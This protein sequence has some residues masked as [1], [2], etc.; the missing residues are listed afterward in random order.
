M[1]SPPTSRCSGPPTPIGS[2]VSNADGLL[3][4]GQFVRIEVPVED[5]ADLGT[6]VKLWG[7]GWE[8]SPRLTALASRRRVDTIHKSRV[9]GASKINLDLHAGHQQINGISSRVFEVLCCGGFVLT[10][11]RKDL[12]EA[13]D[14]GREIDVFASPEEAKD[15][16]DYYLAHPEEREEMARHGRDRVVSDLTIDRAAER[17]LEI[18]GQIRSGG[19]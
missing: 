8:Q 18:L 6:E 5:M 9:Y 14:I 1:P 13:F 10:E 7:K 19:R 15:K 2:P 17:M 3:R 16:I 12:E 4:P 11:Y